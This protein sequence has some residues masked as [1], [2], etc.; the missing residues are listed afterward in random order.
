MSE[1]KR[2]AVLDIGK[3]NAKV[4]VLDC[5]SGE[6]LDVRRCPNMVIAGNPYPHYD[7][8]GLWQFFRD[9]L[10]DLSGSLGFDAISIT[11]HGASGVL[12]DAAG[13][14]ALPVLDYEYE[15]PDDV[16]S[17]YPALCPPFSETFSPALSMGL[18]LGAQIHFQKVAFPA[19]FANVATILTYPQYWAYRLT[20]VAANEAT[21]LGCHTDLWQPGRGTFSSLVDRLDI[22]DKMAPIRSAFDALGPVRPELVA[23]LGL[24]KPVPVYCGI[25]DSNASLLPHLVDREAPFAVVST[26]T[27]VINFAVGGNLE[28]LDP[29]RDTLAN[30]DAYGRAVPSSRFMGGR[31]FELLTAELGL[32]DRDAAFAA[33]PAVLEK[34]LFLT[35]NLSAGSGPYPGLKSQWL[36]ADGASAHEKWAAACLYLALMTDTCLGLI[37][38]KGPAL[39]E[40]PFA[41]NPVYLEALQA[42]LGRQ[43]I[44]VSGST[45][46]SQG[47]GLLAGVKLSAHSKEIV[48]R[49]DKGTV[50]AYAEE[51]LQ[52][53]RAAD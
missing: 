14:L 51:W 28:H 27:W 44:A 40:G 41:S 45:G 19:E 29:A 33:L 39:V 42:L 48:S 31:E 5:A 7:I 21:S 2:I 37:G 46:T 53:I 24:Q 20:G 38:A 15:Y 6:E 49:L 18:N 13:D 52:K 9:T 23:E 26:G 1:A 12:L 10:A 4:L 17:A 50:Q 34:R 11:T 16:R 35:P 25:H 43:V 47:A 30:V 8:D 3:T 36:S 32:L 22:R